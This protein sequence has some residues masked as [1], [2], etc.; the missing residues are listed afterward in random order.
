ML[1]CGGERDA[2]SLAAPLGPAQQQGTHAPGGGATT[3][4]SG[5]AAFL[6]QAAGGD[7]QQQL[8][9][10]SGSSFYLEPWLPPPSV[11][12]SRRGLGPLFNAAA[13]SD[14]HL[15]GGRGRPALGAEDEPAGLVL[16]LGSGEQDEHGAALPD[17]VYGVQL[18]TRALAGSAAEGT[19]LLELEPLLRSYADGSEQL[20]RVP[21][22]RLAELRYGAA[23]GELRLSPR[24]AAATVGLGLLEAIPAARLQALEDPDDRDGDGISGRLNQVWDRSAQALAPGRFGWKAEQP[25]LR[26]QISAAL[27][28]DM[29]VTSLT[30]PEGDCIAAACSAETAAAGAAPELNERVLDRLELYLRLLAVPA[31]RVPEDEAVQR[32]ERWFSELGCAGCHVPAHMTASDAALLQLRAQEIWPYTD[33]LL[34]DL[35][36][37]LADD[38]PSYL[39]QGTE[40]RTPPLWGVGLS[41]QVSGHQRLLHDG[42]AEGVA[43]AILWHGGEAAAARDGFQA[44]GAAQRAEL[45]AFVESL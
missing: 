7:R 14:C 23:P 4:H 17:P 6:Q 40:W 3:E 2:T 28:H 1:G 43:E 35:G 36:A 30:Y 25:S 42:R 10:V 27:A 29:G 19:V 45:V 16:R 12:T 24:A 18:Q 37:E 32:G 39:A 44:L 13:C 33:L 8:F 38:R 9:F 22:Y 34:H 11:S 41:R 15:G 21:R 20:L 31:R 26:Q 5:S